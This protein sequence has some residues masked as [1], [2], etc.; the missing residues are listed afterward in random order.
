MIGIVDDFRLKGGNYF[1][2]TVK[3]SNDFRKLNYLHVIKNLAKTEIDS[4]ENVAAQ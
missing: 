2:I 4:L 1:E 3:L